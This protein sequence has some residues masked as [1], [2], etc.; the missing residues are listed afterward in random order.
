MQ[1]AGPLRYPERAINVRFGQLMRLPRDSLRLARFP[2]RE[3][4]ASRVERFEFAG[5]GLG[6]VGFKLLLQ[7][8]DHRIVPGV[9]EILLHRLHVD[10]LA[11][12]AAIHVRNGMERLVDVT[13]EVNEKREVAGRAPFVVIAISKTACI[14]ID[15]CCDAIVM[16]TP[17]QQIALAILQADVDV[18][19]RCRPPYL[20]RGTR[21]PAELMPRP[22]PIQRNPYLLVRQEFAPRATWR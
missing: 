5:S 3:I 7:H 13:Y 22:S 20:P 2:R 1:R 8:R 15:S 4:T 10:T 16:W 14:L 19:P 21:C 11:R 18:V 6:L 17:R 12:P 9:M